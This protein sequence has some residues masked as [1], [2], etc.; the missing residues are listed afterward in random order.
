MAVA[1]DRSSGPPKPPLWRRRWFRRVLI[2]I[3]GLTLLGVL[4]VGAAALW[5]F[6]ILPRSLPSVSAL[7]TLQPIQGTKIYDDND[8][9]IT[10]LHVERRILV[11]LSQIPQS[12][13]DAIL[14]TE[15][16]RFYSHWGI[17][18]IGV[19]RAIIQNYRRGRIVEGGST[20]TQQ[21]TKVLFL[22]PDKSLE[23]K[24][25][26]AVLALE[27]ER[28]YSKD[29][30][31]EMY[32]NQVYFGQGSYGVEAAARTY[33]G[34][35]VSELTVR[36]S[37]LIAGLPRAPTNYSP[38]DRPEAAKRRREVVLRRLVEFGS[39]KDE[40][41]KRLAK[42][43]LGLIPPERRRTTGQYFIDY[44]QQTLEA[45]YGPDLVLKG[46]LNVYTTLNP[47][48]QLTA[49]QSLREGLKALA[50]RS[51][52]TTTGAR[53]GESPEGA[54]V[55]VEP[56]TGYVK[57]MV[58][59]SDFFR[60]E[61][62]RAVQAKRQPGS[63]FKPFIYIAALEAGFTPASQIEDSPVSFPVGGKNGQV[64]KPENYDRKFRGSTTL[65]QAI[66]ESVN[67][68]TVKLQERVGLA[69]T[70]QVARRLGIT[71]P[72]DVNLSLALGTSDVSLLE[73]TSAY[74]TLANQGVWMPPV[75]IRYVTDA[76]GKLLEEHVPEGR[77]ALAP[78]TA[79]VI[80]QMLRGVVER[81]TGQAA[82]GLGRPVAA[83]TG[84]TNDY[85]NAW[86]VGF[87]P[88]LATGVWVG[89]DRPRSLGKDETGSRVAVPIWV[90]YMGKVL[91][92]SPKED[93]PVPEHVVSMLVDEDPSGECLRPVPMAFVKGTESGM[94]CNGVGQPRAQ[95]VPP[96][97]AT[98]Q[99]PGAAP[100]L[101][102][103]PATTPGPAPVQMTPPAPSA[104]PKGQTP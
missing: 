65:Q 53:P 56:Q 82:K 39:I 4:V 26:E 31:L 27:L 64:W 43:D 99:P 11:P 51:A 9:A 1:M 34:K 103:P 44:V 24:L 68:V 102:S 100:A 49:E 20:I 86:F 62:N 104:P 70:I 55:T 76:Q 5:A 42:T 6:T 87:T 47:T 98:P 77:E 16:R 40:E 52:Q 21:L 54:V 66:E 48:M 80:T 97:T 18:P 41:A 60:S 72:L 35:G 78:E 95:V 93:F 8:E 19:A 79:Y 88:R 57:A 50:G 36:E 33:F 15:D 61:F 32:L 94:T 30:I 84:T 46:G 29:R 83:K 23:R 22:T 2:G 25:K 81:G 92:E 67:V 85:S 69:K 10:E 28:R 90:T 74:G 17:D 45:K 38:F 96:A 91:G 71:S 89:Y 58:G 37:A 14:A 73:M 59:G 12:L 7:E 13:R 75:A 3:G 101:P 63:A